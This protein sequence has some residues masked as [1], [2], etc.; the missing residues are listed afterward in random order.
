VLIPKIDRTSPVPIYKQIRDAVVGMVDDG[1]LAAGE[2]L[3]PTR[4]LARTLGLHRSTLVRA[5]AELWALGYLESR[6]GSYSTVRRR[7]RVMTRGRL[8]SRAAVDWD[9]VATPA[10][11][12]AHET[13]QRLAAARRSSTPAKLADLSELAPDA[14]LSPDGDFRRCLRAVLEEEGRRLLGY[15][16]P[17][18]FGP[19]REA[20]A[21]RLRS[22]GIDVLAR[23]IV[24]TNGA[25][26]A[27]DLALRLLVRPGDRVAVEAPTYGTAL[28]LLRLH[29]VS[30]LGI[31]M[32]PDGL[33]LDVL[34]AEID[35]QRP[36]LVYTIPSFQNPTGITTSQAHRERLL[37]LCR[38]RRIPLLEDGFEEEMK[39]FGKAV[40][41]IK[42]MD[43]HGVVLYVGTFSKVVFPGLRIGWIAAPQPCAERLLALQAACSIAGNTLAQAAMAR[44]CELG[45]YEAHLRR[46]HSVYRRRMQTLLHGL[47]AHMPPGVAWTEPAGGYTLWLRVPGTGRDEQALYR[48]LL[49]EGV[50]LSPGSL[51]F[52]IPPNQAHFRISVSSAGEREILE[53]CRRMG[54]VFANA[55]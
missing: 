25:Q 24:V 21:R 38:S 32:R 3:P 45:L 31:P 4:L 22:H 46:V 41:P 10:A 33:D 13:V 14:T 47:R 52:A 51:Y 5:Y 9:A 49:N 2:R 53:A 28:A 30:C 37:D 18:G 35:R 29:G 15:G 39:Y 40:L 16:D 12:S 34:A 6:P 54:R 17:A 50:R 27:I 55:R 23:E 20:I 8:R 43:A 48:R 44:F 11:R 19:L 1:T 42:S 36:V 7:P 26:Q